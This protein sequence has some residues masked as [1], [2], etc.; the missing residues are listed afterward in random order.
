MRA[1]GMPDM[2]TRACVCCC[3]HTCVGAPK[4][5]ADLVEAVL[6]AVLI[7]S[8]GDLVAVWKVLW[9]LVVKADMEHYYLLK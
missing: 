6:G 9:G 7:D 2:C 1:L 4:L 5:L 8:G 3:D